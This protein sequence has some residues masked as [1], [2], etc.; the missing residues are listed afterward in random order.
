MVMKINVK[1]LSFNISDESR[2]DQDEMMLTFWKQYADCWEQYTFSV[3]D[4][5][6]DKDHSYIDIGA[7]IGPTVLYGS[8]IAKECYC[9]EPDKLAFEY[10]TANIAENPEFAS[11]I[12][13][14]E[15]GIGDSNKKER[16]YVGG[17][18][19]SMSSTRPNQQNLDSFYDVQIY[20]LETAVTQSEIDFKQVNFIKIDIEGGEYALLP[21]LLAYLN[22]VDHFPVLYISLHAPFLF[23]PIWKKN[24]LFKLAA[25]IPKK[26]LARKQNAQIIKLLRDAYGV[27]YLRDGV[28]VTSL[29]QLGDAR[30]FQEIVV[31]KQP[32]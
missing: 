12:K 20:D 17:G 30:A 9:F 23:S 32:W 13:S 4:K 24:V 3:L 5:F 11:K 16:F 10:L 19:T 28:K 2:S 7:W 6:L 22:K 1:N 25:Y 21:S 31:T 18:S 8:Q 26:V 27:V 15:Y 14:F 29:S